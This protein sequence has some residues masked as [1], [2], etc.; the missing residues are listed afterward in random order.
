M[1]RAV[2]CDLSGSRCFNSVVQKM[3]IKEN[4][5]PGFNYCHHLS[6]ST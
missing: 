6:E 5:D 1:N 3:S 4:N 2:C